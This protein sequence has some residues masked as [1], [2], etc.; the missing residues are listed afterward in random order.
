M[1]KFLIILV[2]IL[3]GTFST[4]LLAKDAKGSKD[5]PL[6]SR[7]KGAEIKAFNETDYDEYALGAGTVKN[8]KVET[9][10]IEGKIST[11]IYKLDKKLSTFQ[12]FKNYESVLKRHGFEKILSCTSKT[13]GAH[14][15]KLL[16]K[17]TGSEV[18]YNAVDVYN[19]DSRADYRYLSGSFDNKGKTVYVSLL[20]S[21]NKFNKQ[22]FVAQEIVETTEM[23]M[24]QIT[25]DLKSLE[26][27][28][29]QT[30]KATLHGINFEHNS[31]MLTKSSS[32]TVDILATYLKQ[33]SKASYF[34][35]GHT[36]SNGDYALN[37]KLSKERAETIKKS[38]QAKGLPEK[39]LFAVGV[40]QV[41]PVASNK[42]EQG[43]AENRR[44]ELVLKNR[45]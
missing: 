24:D 16:I 27:A 15:P 32:G 19:M 31:A 1:N 23:E 28:I 34:V 29:N 2:C 38:L 25:I 36:D 45:L 35:V 5:H 21:K 4:A 42:D 44:V 14:F 43:R 10:A 26:Q 11:I 33:N 18:T 3:S 9:K 7:Y 41:A 6:M 22:V 20:I 12:V 8:G 37:M 40:A 39:N 13:C 17:G 30:G